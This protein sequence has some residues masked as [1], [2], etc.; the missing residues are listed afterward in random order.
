[1]PS[2]NGDTMKYVLE[3]EY[4]VK[5]KRYDNETIYKSYRYL[6]IVY[7]KDFP[8]FQ[9]HKKFRYDGCEMHN[10]KLFR[11]SFHWG[12]GYE[13]LDSDSPEWEQLK[14]IPE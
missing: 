2:F 11:I 4:K 1:V 6:T 8:L 3:K 10:V 7:N 5:Y 9:K 13:W 12:E 14:N